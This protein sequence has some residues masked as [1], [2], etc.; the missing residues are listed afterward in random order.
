MTRAFRSASICW[1]PTNDFV[2]QIN[3]YQCHERGR[4]L[5]DSAFTAINAD[6]GINL[7]KVSHKRLF[8]FKKHQLSDA[9]QRDQIIRFYREARDGR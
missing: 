2:N 1:L 4:E 6:E 7:S 5:G 8:D 3:Q 9:E